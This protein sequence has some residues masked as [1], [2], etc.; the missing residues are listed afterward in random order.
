MSGQGLGL[1]LFNNSNSR[2]RRRKITLPNNKNHQSKN[3]CKQQWGPDWE[4]I[5]GPVN[6]Q[7]MPP[8]IVLSWNDN[9]IS[10]CPLSVTI[11]SRFT[12]NPASQRALPCLAVSI[13]ELADCPSLPTCTQQSALMEAYSPGLSFF[14]YF[15]FLTNE[16]LCPCGA[17]FLQ[18]RP[19]SFNR[20]YLKSKIFPFVLKTN[21]DECACCN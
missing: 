6:P 21:G 2:T 16:A 12:G 3:T 18:G 15:L 4:V 20:T 8:T 19:P 11:S 5:S 14:I 10:S 9:N 17:L 1:N 7:L 13:S